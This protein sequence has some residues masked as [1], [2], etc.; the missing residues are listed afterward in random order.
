[1]ILCRAMSHD[2]QH[3]DGTGSN[4]ARCRATRQSV[5][6]KNIPLGLCRG[7]LFQLCNSPVGV[8]FI[9]RSE[10]PLLTLRSSKELNGLTLRGQSSR[11][12]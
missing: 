6:L 8:N 11:G 7:R 5:A 1:V 2:R 4:L 10:Y 12:L 9:P 3:T